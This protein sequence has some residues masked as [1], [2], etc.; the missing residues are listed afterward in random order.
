MPKKKKKKPSKDQHN[1]RVKRSMYGLTFAWNDTDPLNHDV[2]QLGDIHMVSHS[3]TVLKPHALIIFQENYKWIMNGMTF[4]WKMIV[5]C[6]T[7]LGPGAIYE[8]T[9]HCKFE[10]LAEHYEKIVSNIF[11]ETDMDFFLHI[12]M[13]A[14]ILGI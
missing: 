1:N 4:N 13:K 5:T 3:N 9:S 8:L 2:A 12:T 10:D 11:D 6:Q 14:E 7:L